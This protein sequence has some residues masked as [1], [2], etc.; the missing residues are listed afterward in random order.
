MHL[1]YLPIFLATGAAG[2]GFT[3]GVGLIWCAG[4][5]LIEGIDR[6]VSR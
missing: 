5:L 1:H 3:F 6:L 4:N 2:A